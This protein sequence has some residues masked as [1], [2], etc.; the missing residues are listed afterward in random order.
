MK[1]V[2]RQ[3]SREALRDRCREA[4]LSLT[5]QRLVIYEELMAMGEHPSPEALYER[6]RKQ[7]PSLS[8]A[9]VYNNIKTFV[10]HG[11]VREMSIHH[12]SLRLENNPNPHHHLVCTR[13]KAIEDLAEDNFEPIRF[14][15]SIP[16]GFAVHRFSVEVLGLCKRCSSSSKS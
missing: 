10:E 1:P 16:K 7:I 2:A 13:C 3:L 5:H 6:V 12:G 11:L 8:L 9:T 4:G 14:K 15:K